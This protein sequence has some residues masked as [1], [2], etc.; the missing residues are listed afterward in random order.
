VKAAEE[1]A[2]PLDLGC[3]S[4]FAEGRQGPLVGMTGATGFESKFLIDNNILL[5]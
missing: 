4:G 1:P 2:E 5:I 3:K